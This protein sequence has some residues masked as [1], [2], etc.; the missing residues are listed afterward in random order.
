MTASLAE[1]IDI[2]SSMKQLAPRL[3]KG[4]AWTR[5]DC[6]PWPE[7]HDTIFD[8]RTTPSGWAWLDEYARDAADTLSRIPD[9]A[10]PVIAHG[11]WWAGNLRFDHEE[12]VAAFDW[13]F[14]VEPEAIAVGLSAGAYLSDGAPT[15]TQVAAFLVD[16]EAVRSA[17]FSASQRHAATAAVRWVLAFNARCDLAM[18]TGDV[19]PRSALGRLLD[20]RDSY[21]QI[22]W[23]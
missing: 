4:P 19:Q 8:F 2:L 11:D 21:R 6:G 3:G 17:P 16:Y 12:V 20:D 22:T 14:I 9:P 10:G 7:P 5:H 13:D 23:S 1:H 15:P 18:L